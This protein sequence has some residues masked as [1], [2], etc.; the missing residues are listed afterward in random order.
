M[1]WKLSGKHLQGRRVAWELAV[2]GKAL[3]KVIQEGPSFIAWEAQA[4]D[5]G[6]PWVAIIDSAETILGADWI[7]AEPDFVVSEIIQ[8]QQAWEPWFESLF[9]LHMLAFT[10]E[11]AQLLAHSQKVPPPDPSPLPGDA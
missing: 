3:N 5:T 9:D 8:H 11:T 7:D 4:A 10:V 6:R 1:A 2:A